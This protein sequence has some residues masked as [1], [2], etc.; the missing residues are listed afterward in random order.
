MKKF[1]VFLI[2]VGGV[3]AG[4]YFYDPFLK[5][6][7]GPLIGKLTGDTPEPL[8][9]PAPSA[10]PA[11]TPA[12]APAAP[13]LPVP[14]GAPKAAP[15]TP[16]AAPATP[17]ATPAPAAPAPVSEI[18]RLVEQRYPLP[19]FVPLSQI[20][21]NWTS[22][23]QRAFPD[24]IAIQ[25]NVPFVLRGPDGRPIGSSVA[26]P[27][28]LVKPVSLNGQTLII[29]SLANPAMRSEIA[30]DQTDFKQRVETR[31]ND[32]IVSMTN[33]IRNQ[34][35]RAKQ[36]LLAKPEALAALQGAGAGGG[37]F[38][39]ADDPR[40]AP[41]KASL[42]NQGV[43]SFTL[44]EATGFR[45]N[46]P[47]RI[48]GEKFRGLYDTV[49][50]KYEAKTIFGTFPGEAKCLLQ[51]GKVIGWIDPITEDELS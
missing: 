3:A 34:R 32:F 17:A 10:A 1:L 44:E 7:L 4:V 37:S 41:V 46:G 22:V 36:A 20:V 19:Q 5:P 39:S 23:P 38:G 35:E 15:M 18:D 21:N 40:L 12:K 49:T 13:A 51:A 31:Y 6:Y 33:R 50:V 43:M 30:L 16:A 2:L 29:A 45:W 48:N 9:D 28:T 24:Q 11:A 14:G 25:Q 47:E 42:S 27:G 26:V 8:I